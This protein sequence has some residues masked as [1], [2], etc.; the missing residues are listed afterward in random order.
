M[1]SM[2]PELRLKR[3]YWILERKGGI[4]SRSNFT[5]EQQTLAP[6]WH[7]FVLHLSFGKGKLSLFL[8]ARNVYSVFLLV[9]FSVLPPP[10]R[11]ILYAQIAFAV[12]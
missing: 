5:A 10:R 2:Q 6:S 11:C 4:I 1:H 3:V 8:H 9:L 12:T 7:V